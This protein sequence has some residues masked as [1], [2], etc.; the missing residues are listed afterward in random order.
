MSK[1]YVMIYY[2]N[3]VIWQVTFEHL[4]LTPGE[5]VVQWSHDD[6]SM[7]KRVPFIEI[8]HYTVQY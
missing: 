1:P 7:R 4:Y 6:I 2:T 3:D 5:L 8:D